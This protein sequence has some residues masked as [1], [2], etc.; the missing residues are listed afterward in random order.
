VDRRRRR[1]AGGVL[2]PQDS[3]LVE[4]RITGQVAAPE[5]EQRHDGLV[6]RRLGRQVD[7]NGACDHGRIPSSLCISGG[8]RTCELQG[9]HLA[10]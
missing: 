7:L 5:L 4:G 10:T 3:R 6:E 1:L 8:E 2:E 9:N